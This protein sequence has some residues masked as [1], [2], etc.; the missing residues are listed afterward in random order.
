MRAWTSGRR[1]LEGPVVCVNPLKAAGVCCFGDFCGFR[2]QLRENL[3]V[4]ID[5]TGRFDSDPGESK[6]D[7]GK[8]QL[9]HGLKLE[10]VS[11]RLR[12]GELRIADRSFFSL[13]FEAHLRRFGSY[14]GT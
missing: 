6:R 2:P 1:V 13:I 12:D 9:G 5:R 10:P 4:A 8:S 14:A 11:P 3:F 7:T